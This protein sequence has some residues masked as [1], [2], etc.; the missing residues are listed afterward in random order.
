MRSD[1]KHSIYGPSGSKRWMTC[2]ASI[3]MESGIEKGPEVYNFPAEEGTAAHEL[4]EF[5]LREEIRAESCIGKTFNDFEVDQEMANQT[6]KYISYVDGECTWDSTL[7][8]EMRVHMPQI[9]ETMFGT[10]D[11]VIYSPDSLEVIDLKYGRGIVVEVDNNS[12]LMLYAIG[13]LTYLKSKFGVMYG[14]GQQVKLTIVQPRAPHKNGPIRSYWITVSQLKD[15]QRLVK[16]AVVLSKEEVPPFGPS[17]SGCRWCAA[18]PIC[19]AYTKHNLEQLKLDFADFKTPKREFGQKLIDVSSI[20][21]EQIG[22]ILNHSKAITTWLKT[23]ADF[24]VSELSAGKQV[25]GF[26][27]VYGRSIRRWSDSTLAE[28]KLVQYGVDIP[29]LFNTKF[30]TAPQMEKELRPE[31]WDIIKDLVE[32]P[33]GKITL[34]PESDGRRS[35]DP[36]VE[37]QKEWE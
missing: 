36:N 34:A 27:L 26:K 6:Q 23:L 7:G 4:G 32:K 20:S 17:E 16:R 10:A 33:Q 8:I 31:E 15:F 12:Q 24:A 37:A 18:A 29:R 35:I 5:C 2:P 9:E 22:N 11:A 28:N 1:Q 14:P 25:P 13:V 3:Q 21:D 30:K 19:T